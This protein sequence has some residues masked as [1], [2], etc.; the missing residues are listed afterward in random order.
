VAPDLRVLGFTAAASVLTGILFGLSPALRLSRMD[1]TPALKECTGELFA[2]SGQRRGWRSDRLLVVAQVSISIVLLIGAVAFVRTLV[3]LE[4]INLGL[5]Q[6][7]LLLFGIDPT[8]DGYKGQRVTDFYQELSRRIE[9]LPGVRSVGLSE[10]TL[11]GGGAS[12]LGTKIEGY[13]SKGGEQNGV[14]GAFYKKGGTEV[15]RDDGNSVDPW[16]HSY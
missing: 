14:K 15:L 6:H 11:I 1:L 8:Q 5:D 13:S 10:N 3:N 16:A 2:G 12:F 4:K 7:N 9:A